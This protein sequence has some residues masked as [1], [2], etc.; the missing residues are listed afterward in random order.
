MMEWQVRREL[1]GKPPYGLDPENRPSAAPTGP[2]RMEALSGWCIVIIRRGGP[3]E[4]H[5][6]GPPPVQQEILK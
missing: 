4:R 3:I 6:A 5:P 1:K 2:A